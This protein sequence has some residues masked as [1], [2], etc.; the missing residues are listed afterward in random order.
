MENAFSQT[1]VS[2]AGARGLMQLMPD[3]ARGLGVNPD[4]PAQ[5]VLGGA[6]YIKQMLGMFGNNKELALAAY[7]AGPGRVQQA[8]KQAGSNNWE[9]IRNY[10]PQETQNYVPKVLRKY[11]GG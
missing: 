3:T 9:D 2:S 1:G 11:G 6:K 4:D 5:N 7:N 8:I 10:L